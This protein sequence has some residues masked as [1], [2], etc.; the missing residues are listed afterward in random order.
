MIWL[1]FLSAKKEIVTEEYETF[2][3]L[4]SPFAPYITEEIWQSLNPSAKSIH[5][6]S[7]PIFNQQYLVADEVAIVVQ[8]NGRV[9][10]TI[11]VESS[12]LKVQSHVEEKARKSEKVNKYLEANQIKKVVYVEG[13]IIN[14]VV[15]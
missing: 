1:N 12:K 9:R 2:L 4:L 7:W 5:L 3:K 14:F 10:D 6:E 15:G 8:V 11:R 13:T